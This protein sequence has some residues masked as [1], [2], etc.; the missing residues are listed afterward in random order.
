MSQFYR[1]AGYRLGEWWRRSGHLLARAIAEVVSV[2]L[3]AFWVL[4]VV[5][6]L[7]TP[8]DRVDTWAQ[9]VVFVPAVCG[10]WL[11]LSV[12]LISLLG[13]LIGLVRDFREYRDAHPVPDTEEEDTPS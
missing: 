11:G 5:V 4:I 12:G 8:A 1:W 6:V 3:V 13:W 2:V 7:S 10:L 9:Y